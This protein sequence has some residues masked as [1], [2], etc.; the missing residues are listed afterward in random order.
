M[1]IGY[2]NAPVELPNGQSGS[3]ASAEC[4]NNALTANSN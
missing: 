4:P 1:K 3:Q 2:M